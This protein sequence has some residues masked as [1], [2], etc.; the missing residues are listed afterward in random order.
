[1]SHQLE[2]FPPPR[3]ERGLR[4]LTLYYPWS[5]MTVLYK[6]DK[7]GLRAVRILGPVDYRRPSQPRGRLA[8]LHHQDQSSG[9]KK[10]KAG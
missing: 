10:G 9:R 1:M 3:K 4:P 8:A 6:L 5:G 7:L 2:L